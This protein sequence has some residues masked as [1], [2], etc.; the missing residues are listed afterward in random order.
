MQCNDLPPTLGRLLHE[1][2]HTP[3]CSYFTSILR[4]HSLACTLQCF[5]IYHINKNRIKEKQRKYSNRRIDTL[6]EWLQY[7]VFLFSCNNTHT[8][9]W[10]YVTSKAMKLWRFQS[11]L[12]MHRIFDTSQMYTGSFRGRESKIYGFQGAQDGII[13]SPILM[14]IFR[15]IFLLFVIKPY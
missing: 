9:I 12:Q 15:W 14:E 6:T 4:H 8:D 1:Q 13:F 3:S 7:N 10:K 5:I 11:K 2:L